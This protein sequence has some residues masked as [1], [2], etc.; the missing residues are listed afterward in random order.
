MALGTDPHGTCQA[1][2]SSAKVLR[3]GPGLYQIGHAAWKFLESLESLTRL[4]TLY[5]T[6][7]VHFEHSSAGQ[8]DKYQTEPHPGDPPCCASILAPVV[9]GSGLDKSHVHMAE[10]IMRP[11]PAKARESLEL[12][13]NKFPGRLVLK[14][15][16]DVDFLRGRVT[17]RSRKG[18]SV[19]L[20]SSD[21][22]A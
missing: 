22:A 17:N 11:V 6:F 2:C 15:P 10:C 21:L 4:H 13:T 3:P 19:D 14:Q 7:G 18:A 16:T 20:T 9:R 1:Q 12:G 8:P 5:S